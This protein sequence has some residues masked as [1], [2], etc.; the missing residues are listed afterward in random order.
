MK[1]TLRWWSPSQRFLSA[2]QARG[3]SDSASFEKQRERTH[4]ESVTQLVK[5][6]SSVLSEKMLDYAGLGNVPS[7]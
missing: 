3:C 4:T 1:G 7:A 6:T 2:R 5:V